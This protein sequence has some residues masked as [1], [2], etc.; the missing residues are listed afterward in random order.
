MEVIYLKNPIRCRRP[1]NVVDFT[2][3]KNEGVLRA[4]P[5]T[6]SVVMA[7]GL[8]LY[9]ETPRRSKP[10]QLAHGVW[11]V[12]DCVASL[13]LTVAAVAVLFAVVL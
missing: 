9:D 11:R 10:S 6:V 2:S 13:A 1:N 4:L 5:A 7:D 12:L 3:Y 8:P